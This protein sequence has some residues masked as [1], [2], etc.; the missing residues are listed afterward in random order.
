MSERKLV[1]IHQPTFF[2]WLGYY[3]KIAI[4][5]I[6][7]ILDDVQFPKTGGTWSNRVKVIVEGKD[8]WIT[9]PIIRSY[10]GTRLINEI[11]INNSTRWYDKIIRTIEFNYNKAE[12]FDELFPFVKEMLSSGHGNLAEYNISII[13]SVCSLIGIDAGKMVRSSALKHE[14]TATDLLIS[15]VGTLGANAYMCGGGAAKYQE[16][17]KFSAAGIELVYQNYSH[18]EYPQI[19]TKSF[20][21]GLSIIDPLLNIGTEGVK[22]LLIRK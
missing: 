6:F 3:D 16:D 14:G 13:T 1:V 4:S 12:H 11:E 20:I 18:P 5:D 19:N 10:S 7:V 8:A 15:I 17:E 2:S 22:N 21:P 9:I